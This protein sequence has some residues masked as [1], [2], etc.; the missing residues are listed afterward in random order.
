[1]NTF[2]YIEEQVPERQSHGKAHPIVGEEVEAVVYA[3]VLGCKASF[4]L[5]KE[6]K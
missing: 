6:V 1:M 4:S 5:F 3:C 2:Q